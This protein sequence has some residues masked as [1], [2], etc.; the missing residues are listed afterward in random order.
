[1]L[2]Q[3]FFSSSA[4]ALQSCAIC[5]CCSQYPCPGWV[6]GQGAHPA[7]IWAHSP[8][9][10]NNFE[11]ASQA[12]FSHA[13]LVWLRETPVWPQP[14]V[15]GTLAIYSARW[16]WIHS[17]LDCIY[18]CKQHAGHKRCTHGRHQ[19]HRAR[20]W[21][22]TLYTRLVLCLPQEISPHVLLE[23]TWEKTDNGKSL[24]ARRLG[25]SDSFVID[26]VVY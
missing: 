26:A 16:C 14:D 4:V 25:L 23:C 9:A 2:K 3:Q 13:T 8:G 24:V 11:M 1:M 10:H 15:R 20:G 7:S 6:L 5:L 21:Y 19:E 17:P 18:I 12:V 22:T